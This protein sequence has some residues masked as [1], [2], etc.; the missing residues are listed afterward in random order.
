M[1]DRAVV[2]D[3]MVDGT[4]FIVTH[5]IDTHTEKQLGAFASEPIARNYTRRW[6]KQHH[7]ICILRG[8]IKEDEYGQTFVLA[9][10]DNGEEVE[11]CDHS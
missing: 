1:P 8:P 6:S 4:P 3:E 2:D 10:F 5:S 9:I 11:D 7:G